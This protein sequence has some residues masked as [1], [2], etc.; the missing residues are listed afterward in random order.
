MVEVVVEDV[1]ED[2]SINPFGPNE[3]LCGMKTSPPSTIKFEEL[4]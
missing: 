4:A 2:E 3:K 1:D